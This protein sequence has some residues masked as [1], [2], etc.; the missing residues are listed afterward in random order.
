M[1]HQKETERCSYSRTEMKL[2]RL[3]KKTMGFKLGESHAPV[4]FNPC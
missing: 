4:P 3:S 2:L 1:L